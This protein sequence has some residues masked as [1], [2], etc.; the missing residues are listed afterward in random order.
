[1]VR[2]FVNFS[3]ILVFLKDQKGRYS[4]Q[5]GLDNSSALLSLEIP[6][7]STCPMTPLQVSSGVG[8]DSDPSSFL[9]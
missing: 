8:V 7:L 5:Y 6:L 2:I 3:I 1:M 4:T 9:V